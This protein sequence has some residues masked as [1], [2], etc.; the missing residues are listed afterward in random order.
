MALKYKVKNFLRVATGGDNV[1]QDRQQRDWSAVGRTYG[2]RIK[3]L[4]E[5][6]EKQVLKNVFFSCN[7]YIRSW[8]QRI[9]IYNQIC[10]ELTPNYANTR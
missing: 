3:Y 6:Q 9:N 10:F 7:N 1:S 2:L 5:R 8:R 4:P